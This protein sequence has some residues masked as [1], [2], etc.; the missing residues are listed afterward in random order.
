MA[1]LQLERVSNRDRM[2]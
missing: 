2:P 1:Q